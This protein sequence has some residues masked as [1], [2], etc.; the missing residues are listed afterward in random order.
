MKVTEKALW[1][2]AGATVLFL[3]GCGGGGGGGEQAAAPQPEAPVAKPVLQLSGTAAVGAALAQADVKVKCAAGSGGGTTSGTGTYSVAIT[4]GTLPCMVAVTGTRGAAVVV[5]HSLAETGAPGANAGDVNA[6]A[7]VSPVTEMA[8]AQLQGAIPA[9]SFAA[10]AGEAVS[11]EQL[12]A[13]AGRVV[14]LLKEAGIDLGSIDPFKADLVVGTSAGP[15]NQYDQALDALTAKV[16]P[17]A[18]PMVVNHIARSAAASSDEGLHQ[19][20]L[21][22]SGGNLAGC[23][24]ALSGDYRAIEKWGNVVT[25]HIDF[26]S[27]KVEG[28]IPTPAGLVADA[29]RPCEFSATGDASGTQV[30]MKAVIGTQGVGAMSVGLAGVPE[31]VSMAYLVPVQVHPAASFRGSWDFL[32]SEALNLRHAVGRA[33]FADDGK[34]ARCE[35]GALPWSCTPDAATGLAATERSDGGIQFSLDAQTLL[36]LYGYRGPS[37]AMSV[38][39]GSTERLQS[40][41]LRPVAGVVATQLGPVALPTVGSVT[42][43]WDVNMTIGTG[44]VLRILDPAADAY[45]ILASDPGTGTVTRKRQSDGREDQVQ[46][47]VPIDGMKRRPLGNWSGTAFPEIYQ[48]PLGG[49]GVT[50]SVNAQPFSDTAPYVYNIAVLR[51]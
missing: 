13:A 35:Y 10:F 44:N 25:L 16:D 45:T 51:P 4:E 5:L 31:R 12:S 47:N 20:A 46:Y 27:M 14:A 36:I 11:S 33:T 17:D 8:L 43:T 6:V 50:L 42:K 18:L 15:G 34:L 3:A 24:A 7:N 2:A 37:G 23:P 30:E 39:G 38:F 21:A 49:A 48:F 40:G 28:F 19:A 29:A 22:V 41:G 1:A 32:Q 26:G 9:D